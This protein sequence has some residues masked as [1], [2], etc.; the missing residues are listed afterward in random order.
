MNTIDLDQ[1][2]ETIR[3]KD[4]H[5]EDGFKEKANEKIDE[6]NLLLNYELRDKFE[7]LGLRGDK[8]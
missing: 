1:Q 2:Y 5:K 8:C 6:V 7:K 4:V 3:S